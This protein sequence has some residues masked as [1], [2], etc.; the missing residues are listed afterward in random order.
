[1][2]MKIN[3]WKA[4]NEE[5]KQKKMLSILVL[6]ILI[7]STVA[8][9]LVSSGGRIVPRTINFDVR[10]GIMNGE[11]YVPKGVTAED[12]L[13]AIIISAGGGASNGQTAGLAQELAR[14]GFVVFN[15]NA[16]GA[17]Q[18]ECP[19]VDDMDY[20]TGEFYSTRGL[21]DALEY[22]RGLEYV[23][24]TRIGM[25][26]HSM[27]DIRANW[28]AEKDGS[29]LT[30]N[31]R[32]LDILY[33]EFEVEIN[34]EQLDENADEIAADVLN[35]EQLAYYEYLAEE[36][37][38]YFDTRVKA[39]LGIGTGPE[40]FPN[41]NAKEVEVAGHV[42]NRVLNVNLGLILGKYD[43]EL[44]TY[45]FAFSSEL[46]NVEG[47]AW[48]LGEKCYYTN[49]PAADGEIYLSTK[50][51]EENAS[52][53]LGRLLDYNYA[54]EEDINDAFDSRLT[55]FYH[56]SNEDH[57]LNILSTETAGY[58][59]KYFEAA[60][61]YNNGELIDDATNPIPYTSINFIWREILTLIA[62]FS[63]F[64]AIF[65]LASMFLQKPMFSSVVQPVATPR[66]NKKSLR[67]WLGSLVIA[68]TGA[69]AVFIV[70]E[71]KLTSSSSTPTST[72]IIPPSWFFPYDCTPI[73]P[74]N[75]MVI[76]FCASII[77]II[78][79]CLFSKQVTFKDYITDYGLDIGL[80][81]VIKLLG[82]SAMIMVIAYLSS[83]LI[84]KFFHVDYGFWLIDFAVMTP[85]QI[86]AVLRYFLLLTV[87]QLVSGIF[88]NSG[89]MTDMTEGKNTALNLFMADAGLVIPA[90]IIYAI[91][92]PG[93][94][95]PVTTFYMMCAM[96]PFMTLFNAY[97]SRKMYN[98]TGSVWLGAFIN[99]WLISWM[100]VGCTDTSFLIR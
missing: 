87:L 96:M 78:V 59:V 80:K 71:N 53:G 21:Y 64:G 85:Q 35:E 63:M 52:V 79:S 81:K 10:G 30:L 6:I 49:G 28:A 50:E 41:Y 82:L 88:V 34:E 32:L 39:V 90:I 91:A 83:G 19:P 70:Y 99:A 14:R 40:S 86:F 3:F 42:V 4:L 58:V 23:D 47:V 26:G 2:K 46:N 61:Q 75:W 43:E 16:Y 12:S 62:M 66:V 9:F 77:V 7:C 38:K 25:T 56:L 57:V 27:G 33:H 89:R 48:Y 65:V 37:E 72:D 15:V 97:V 76:V 94:H 73:I 51:G 60:L 100:W 95:S 13:P 98:L 55:R 11:L 24:P 92:I 18:S 22:V 8:S 74:L 29:Y 45:S 1:M 36:E 69:F 5:K 17:G 44:D 84:Y 31:D 93:I 20:P 67:F 68:A 54:D